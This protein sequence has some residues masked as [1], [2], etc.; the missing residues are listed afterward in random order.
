MLKG[1]PLVS[2]GMK[3]DA[4][5]MFPP[6][7]ARKP[8]VPFVISPVYFHFLRQAGLSLEQAKDEKAIDRESH[9]SPRPADDPVF[10]RDKSMVTKQGTHALREIVTSDEK[11]AWSIMFHFFR[12]AGG[13]PGPWGGGLS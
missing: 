2:L 6:F 9:P 11:E 5:I 1:R 3:I 7:F 12:L 4:S 10:A 8:P 13:W